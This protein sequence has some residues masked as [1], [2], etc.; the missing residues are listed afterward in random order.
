MRRP[1]VL[2]VEPPPSPADCYARVARQPYTL[3]LDSAALHPGTGRYSFI[4]VDPFQVLRYENERLVRVS[5]AGTETLAGEPFQALGRLLTDCRQETISGIPPFQGGAAGYVGYE[6]GRRLERIPLTRVRDLHLPD[7]ELGVYD[8]VAAWDH[9]SDRCWLIST[10]GLETGRAA[11]QQARHRLEEGMQ[12]LRG[13]AFPRMT[14][15]MPDAGPN[16]RFGTS[17]G[18]C[19]DGSASRFAAGDERA[20]RFAVG[21]RP[22]LSST[23]GRHGYQAAVE[24]AIEYILAGDVFEVNLSQ[25][26]ETAR[27]LDPVILY[28][29]LREEN[30]APFGAYFA[31]SRGAVLSSSPER[32][33]A[34]DSAGRVE[35]R[36]IKGTRPRADDPGLDARLARELEES[37]KDLAENLMIVDLLRNDLSRVCV[38]DSVRVPALFRLESYATVH[39]LVSVVTG[40]LEGGRSAADLLAAA[41]PGG[42]VTGAPKVR[43]MEII[44]ELEPVPRGPYCGA[45]GYLGFDGAADTSIAI[46][47]IIE[48]GDR[49]VCHAGGAVTAD[50]VPEAEYE[51]TLHKAAGLLGA[52][53]FGC[54]AD[55][56]AEAAG[57]GAPAQAGS[58]GALERTP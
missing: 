16:R 56:A 13:D 29:R 41:F 2:P 11:E 51:E 36:P 37:R 27:R 17:A 24:R 49:Y 45:I 25:R 48:D 12:W 3:W 9:E 43:A 35:T 10:G 23:F 20:P 55:A 50:S 22:G 21:D 52:L 34:A 46:R 44:D 5:A 54:G 8:L 42:S 1:L 28:L 33:L 14:L 6:L 58:P 40:R 18:R 38:P 26:F 32:F 53:G 4:A 39:H 57:S 19:E 15:P 31:G 30:P 47:I 7:L